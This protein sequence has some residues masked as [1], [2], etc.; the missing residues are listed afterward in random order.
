MRNRLIKHL[1]I[2][3][4]QDLNVMHNTIDLV[5][6]D[7]LTAYEIISNNYSLK[8]LSLKVIYNSMIFKKNYVVI[9]EK[10]KEQIKNY[11]PSHWGIICIG[12]KIEII[13]EP[14]RNTDYHFEHSLNILTKEDLVQ[15]CKE[16]EIQGYSKYRKPHL[17]KYISSLVEQE[18]IES[19]VI[20][21]LN[22]NRN[23]KEV[24]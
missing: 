22:E 2:K 1:N 16:K 8:N 12:L 23:E 9:R 17:V 10:H 7:D 11:I 20:Q 15:L 3:V 19:Y 21:K 14:G 4:L 6:L 24:G 13:R 5:S 18:R